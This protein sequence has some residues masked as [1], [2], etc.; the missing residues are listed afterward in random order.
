MA[1]FSS[2]VYLIAAVVFAPLALWI[3][4]PTDAHPSIA[5]L[6]RPW[7]VPSLLDWVV[8][9]GLGLVWASWAY[10]MARAYSLAEASVAAPFEYLS[11][12][13][14]ITWG[15]VFWRELPSAMTLVGASVALMSGLYILFHDRG[16]NRG[17]A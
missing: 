10:C 13:I 9:S 17:R 5:F 1:Y 3:G 16:R 14:N 7:A 2:L 11:L 8:M 15:F 6:L 12:L 4:E